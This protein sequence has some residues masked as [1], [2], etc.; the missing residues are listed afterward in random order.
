MLPALISISVFL[1]RFLLKYDT[2]G[3]NKQLICRHRKEC[4]MSHSPLLSIIVP[5]Y[6][7]E[8]YLCQCL[9]SLLAQNLS[10]YE[11]ILVDDGSTDQSGMIC[12]RYASAHSLFQCVHKPNGGLPSARKC[13]FEA[14]HG[15]YVTFVDSDDWVSSDMYG[16]MCQTIHDTHADVVICDYIAAMPD[17]EEICTTPF[18]TGFYDKARLETEVYPFMLYTGIFYKYGLAPSLCNKIFRRDLLGRHLLRVPNDV[19]VGEDAMASY[20]CLLEADSAFILK[21]AFYYYRSNASSVS[22]QAMP[23]RR[24]QDNHKLF[25]TLHDVIDTA[26]YPCMEKQLDYYFVYQCL[27]T[28]APV[29]TS[30]S[31]SPAVLRQVFREECNFPL[32]RKAFARI[33]V[34]EIA[35]I[36]NKLY[37][38]CIRHRF[39]YG[40]YFALRH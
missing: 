28:F 11:V 38:L 39:F 6:N 37:A 20:S 33:P 15:Q 1:L 32:I 5:V 30:M 35:G 9:D 29:F 21:E 25:Q 22:H 40:F 3:K 7:V 27:L 31:A 36:H 23:A 19:V 16:R 4:P 18:P 24:L 13:G 10:D 26:A 14:S 17:R 34:K 2:M 8:R 12:D